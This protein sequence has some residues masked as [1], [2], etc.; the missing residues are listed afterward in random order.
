MVAKIA[1]LCWDVTDRSKEPGSE[2][3]SNACTTQGSSE[4]AGHEVQSMV[5]VA[6]FLML[7]AQGRPIVAIR[8]FAVSE[9]GPKQL[10]VISFHQPK[11]PIT[12]FHF[13]STLINHILCTLSHVERHARVTP[14]STHSR[15][16][17]STVPDR[18]PTSPEYSQSTSS[19]MASSPASGEKLELKLNDWNDVVSDETQCMQLTPQNEIKLLSSRNANCES[20]AITSS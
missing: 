7:D 2:V 20:G 1:G 18:S 17:S 14:T 12:F 3:N 11:L 13:S 9:P 6:Q 16:K 19:L 5:C 8:F 15:L 10:A 4:S